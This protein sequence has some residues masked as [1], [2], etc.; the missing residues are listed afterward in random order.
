MI[1]LELISCWWVLLES[2][3][4]RSIEW[5]VVPLFLF[6]SSSFSSSSFSSSSSPLC[7]PLKSYSFTTDLLKDPDGILDKSHEDLEWQRSWM[8]LLSCGFQLILSSF[9]LRCSNLNQFRKECSKN[10][11]RILRSRKDFRLGFLFGKL[12]YPSWLFPGNQVQIFQELFAILPN[13]LRRWSNLPSADF[14]SSAVGCVEFQEFLDGLTNVLTI[15]I[16]F[17][18]LMESVFKILW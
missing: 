6:L 17:Q 5:A 4:D 10:P 2:W 7:S 9:R 14:W 13:I 3:K 8:H 16:S 12:E 15:T 11:E 1:R 18:S